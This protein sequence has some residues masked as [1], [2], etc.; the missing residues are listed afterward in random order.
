MSA[1]SA[2]PPPGTHPRARL[3][4]RLT[5]TR[6]THT[7]DLQLR[8]P[9]RVAPPEEVSEGSYRP[10]RAFTRS[11]M[12][13]RILSLAFFLA[14]ISAALPATASARPA[15]AGFER[16]PAGSY[17][18]FED[19]DGNGHMVAFRGGSPD[20]RRQNMDNK[21]SSFANNSGVMWCVFDDYRY[22]QAHI[23]HGA[24]PR[25]RGNFGEI[26]DL[27]SSTRAGNLQTGCR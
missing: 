13:T 3:A 2:D 6:R 12:R 17:C 5:P 27:A 18:L 26:N 8:K 16:C 22:G 21:A 25:L 4:A 9:R 19:A 10:P 1:A 14:A 20:L 15:L 23:S 24:L 7:S 11:I